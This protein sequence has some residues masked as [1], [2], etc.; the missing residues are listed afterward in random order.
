M[1]EAIKWNCVYGFGG[2]MMYFML[3]SRKGTTNEM[4]YRQLYRDFFVT[5]GLNLM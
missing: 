2:K 3:E 5:C 1:F 4:V